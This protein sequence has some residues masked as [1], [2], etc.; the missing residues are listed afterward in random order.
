MKHLFFRTS[1]AVYLLF[2][3]ASKASAEQSFRLIVGVYPDVSYSASDAG[4]TLTIL[5]NKMVEQCGPVS[6]PNPRRIE[7]SGDLPSNVVMDSRR[8]K[9]MNLYSAT[10]TSVQVVPIIMACPD[11]VITGFI[12]GCARPGGPIFVRKRPSRARDAQVWGHEIGHAQGLNSSFSGYVGGHNQNFGFLM[13]A[14]ASENNWAMTSAECNQ[15]YTTQTFPPADQGEA[16]II[17]EPLAVTGEISKKTDAPTDFDDEQFA[18]SYLLAE[19]PHGLD[20]EILDSNREIVS[21]MAR[22]ALL[23]DDVELWPNSVLVAGYTNFDGAVSLISKVLETTNIDT[24]FATENPEEA[25]FL[26]NDAKVNA[27]VA[28][29][30]LAFEGREE[31]SNLLVPLI[32]PKNNFLSIP[33][34]DDG[35]DTQRLSQHLAILATTGLALAASNNTELQTVLNNHRSAA[36]VGQYDLG[37][38]DAFFDQLEELGKG[39]Q[40]KTLDEVLGSQ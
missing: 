25:A 6:F 12:S 10:G 22:E 23:N 18:R 30:Y 28:L 11:P 26:V 9:H 32:S 27:G 40:G 33:F 8:P 1:V 5:R 3:F 36:L 4:K 35:R 14:S 2:C 21:R 37:V 13:Y 20:S 24:N 15:Y 17:D 29:G 39:A 38:D 34:L 31:A 16:I 7:L 19:W